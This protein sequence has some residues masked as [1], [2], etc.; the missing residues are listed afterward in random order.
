MDVACNSLRE[1]P[2]GFLRAKKRVSEMAIKKIGA[3]IAL[4][5]EKTIQL[6]P[7]VLPEAAV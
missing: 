5:G 3:I 6:A 2:W 7:V 1:N 4:D